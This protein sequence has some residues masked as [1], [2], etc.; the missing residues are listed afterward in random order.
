MANGKVYQ[1][2][3]L[4]QIS[5]DYK[6]S[7]DA[8]LAEKIAPIVN[9]DKKTGVYFEY[10]KES[11]RKPVST[12]RTGHAATPVFEYS[13]IKRTY[14]PLHEHDL[15]VG[16]TR[17]EY[18]MYSDPLSPE[19]DAVNNLN[20]AMSIEKEVNL[21]TKLSDTTVITQNVNLAT[22]PT[23]QW[24]DYANSSPFTDIQTGITS[25]QTNGLTP[26]N[27]I[28]MGYQVW[29]QLVNHPDLLDR[30][31]FSSLGVL[32]TDL[33]A[34]LFSTAG[35][36][37]VWVGAAVYNS[38]QEGLTASNGFAWGKH[39]WL[40]YVTPTPGLRTLNGAYTLTQSQGK[41]VDRWDEQ[42]GKVTWI[43]NNDY[44]EQKLVGVEAFYLIKNAVA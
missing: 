11:L 43:R 41:Y 44:Y 42:D 35:I 1:D 6:N 13:V 34:R 37:N 30:V 33:L 21:S 4:T 24:N 38:A 7:N 40:A 22:V 16:I 12:L 20:Q 36:T 14:G 26:P 19:T 39:F 27:T 23:N 9:V 10:G 15:K 3:V 17:D 29:A 25:L 18:N 5:Q 32:T 8:F 28:F 2:P 31:K